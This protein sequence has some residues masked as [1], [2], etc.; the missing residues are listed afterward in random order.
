MPQLAPAS[1]PPA[2]LH[3]AI[4]MDGNGRWAAR[5]RL[6]RSVGH[7]RGIDAVKRT[8]EAATALGIR[9]L[10]L[11]GFST[12]NW[13]RPPEEVATLM[14]LL[15]IFLRSE[16]SE[17]HA[18]G[19]RLRFI[20]ERRRLSP[21]IVALI[22]ESEILTRDNAGLQLT[23]A[24]SYGARQ[25][26]AEAARRLAAEVAAGRLSP[27]AIDEE[28]VARHLFAPDLPDPDLVIRTSG[29][30]RMSNFLLW[31][32]AYAELVFVDVLWPDFAREHLEAALS[33]FQRRERRYGSVG[34]P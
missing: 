26:L 16:V 6:P 12:E 18:R 34:A 11:F 25:E 4:I 9:H 20:G 5:R 31:Q 3:V 17:L 8:I 27:E 32:V 22:E 19:V 33:E 28:L 7:R 21:E 1:E 15:L 14:R 24:L 29:E 30:K 13:R 23:I 2:P 10:T